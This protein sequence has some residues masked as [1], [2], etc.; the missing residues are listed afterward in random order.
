MDTVWTW[1]TYLWKLSIHGYCIHGDDV[2]FCGR[3]CWVMRW[4]RHRPVRWPVS[5]SWHIAIVL[6]CLRGSRWL[7]INTDIQ[8]I[9]CLVKGFAIGTFKNTKISF[10][11]FHFWFFNIRNQKLGRWMHYTFHFFVMICSIT[12]FFIFLHENF[13]TVTTTYHHSERIS[14]I[15]LVSLTKASDN[16]FFWKKLQQNRSVEC[17]PFLLICGTN[18]KY[19]HSDRVF[20]CLF[21]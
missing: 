7:I 21:V 1:I 11:N 18:A 3:W 20:V 17:L 4:P 16:H 8:I 6:V 12:S 5:R 14:H 15:W 13:T 9:H 10:S 19:R 2:P